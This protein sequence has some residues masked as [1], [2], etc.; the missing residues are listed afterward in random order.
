MSKQTHGKAENNRQSVYQL[1]YLL[2]NQNL[3]A[4][5]GMDRNSFPFCRISRRMLGATQ[6]P[7]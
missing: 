2:D 7:V 1:G 4:I 5:P 3:S 6:S